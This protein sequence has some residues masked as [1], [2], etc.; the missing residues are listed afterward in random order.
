MFP[1]QIPVWQKENFKQAKSEQYYKQTLCNRVKYLQLSQVNPYDTMS[2]WK[3]ARLEIQ[4]IPVQI[5]LRAKKVQRFIEH[6]VTTNPPNL[7]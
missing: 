2:Q 4:R 3:S 6:N 5:L 1:V 7:S